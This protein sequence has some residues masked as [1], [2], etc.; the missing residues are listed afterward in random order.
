[1]THDDGEAVPRATVPYGDGEVL[2]IGV[3]AIAQR[4]AQLGGIIKADATDMIPQAGRRATGR[5]HVIPFIVGR[6]F[7]SQRR[8][9]RISEV[10]QYA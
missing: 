6:E 1:M 7:F 8:S 2:A 4:L 10:L 3:N 9:I 5:T